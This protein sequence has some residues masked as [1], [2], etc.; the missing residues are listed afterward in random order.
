MPLPSRPRRVLLTRP[1]HAAAETARR[2]A[3][4]GWEA[5]PA[6]LL[7]IH[8]ADGPLPPLEGGQAVLITSANAV[9]FLPE[10]AR[11]LP[12]FAV[13][14]AS[15]AAARAAGF[16]RAESAAGDGAALIA[17]VCARLRPEAGPLW[18]A[19]GEGQGKAAAAA[20]ER[21]GFIVRRAEVYRAVPVPALPGEAEAALLAPATSGLRAAL[22]FSAETARV[23]RRHY[24][25]G[26][27]RWRLDQLRAIAISRA[28]APLLE[29][30]PWRGVA[31]AGRPD[32]ES[33]LAR[34]AEIGEEGRTPS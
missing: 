4:L 34:L 10:A 29:D 33:L 22:F 30:L 8:P 24:E 17:R 2:L 9:P 5:I 23:F 6:P 11:S 7:D 28:S 1:R 26:G 13:G 21:A 18:L 16:V 32:Q 20:L 31:Y 14:E 25:A 15:A 12:L 3:A 27:Q 19:V